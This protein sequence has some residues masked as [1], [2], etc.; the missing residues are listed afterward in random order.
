MNF[1]GLHEIAHRLCKRR[2]D[3]FHFPPPLNFRFYISVLYGVYFDSARSQF[4]G[5]GC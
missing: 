1:E 2:G 4:G 3:G 5:Y